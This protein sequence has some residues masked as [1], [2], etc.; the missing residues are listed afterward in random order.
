[1]EKYSENV[2]AVRD[3]YNGVEG[4]VNFREQTGDKVWNL[5]HVVELLVK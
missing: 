4:E 2:C 5:W 1:M 3:Y